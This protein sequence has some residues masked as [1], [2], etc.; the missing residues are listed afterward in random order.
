ML[1]IIS[2]G[3]MHTAAILKKLN[4]S[5]PKLEPLV[6]KKDLAFPLALE[7]DNISLQDLKKILRKLEA[8]SKIEFHPIDGWHVEKPTLNP[9]KFPRVPTVEVINPAQATTETSRPPQPRGP[10]NIFLGPPTESNQQAPPRK[11]GRG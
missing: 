6:V 9:V 2:N 4:K 1:E 11:P 10:A 3:T 8:E 5:Q 7:T